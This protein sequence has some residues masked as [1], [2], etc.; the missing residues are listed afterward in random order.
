M[1][2]MRKKFLLCWA[3]LIFPLLSIASEKIYTAKN[4]T[5]VVSAQ[6]PQFTI[7]LKANPT[8]GF[9]WFLKEHN[10][11]TV[12]PLKHHFQPAKN[13]RLIGTPGYEEWT[14]KVKNPAFTAS[15]QT[16][17]VFI[18]ARPWE[19]AKSATQVVFTVLISP[20]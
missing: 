8:T 2:P 15:Q 14:F 18:Y 7:Q 12:E 19:K 16:T 11:R 20:K 4:T 1:K 9:S 6:Q 10:D 17:L 3:T 13:S 5:I